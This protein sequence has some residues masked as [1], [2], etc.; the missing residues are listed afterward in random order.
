MSAVAGATPVRDEDAFDVERIANW[1]WEN[2]PSGVG[3]NGIPEVQQF[4]GGASNL[5][6]L[7][8]YGGGPD[9]GGRDLV[10]RRPPTGTKAR[11]AHDMRR[12]H[13]IQAALAPVFPAVPRMV[14]FCADDDVIGSQFYV[15]ERL[16]GTILRRNVPPELGLGPDGIATLCRAAVDTLVALHDVDVESAGLAA[17]DRGDGYVHRQVEGWCGR[18]RRARTD[19]VGDFEATMAWLVSHQPADRPH[20]LI[21]NDF[22]FDNLVLAPGDP[23]RIVGVLDW[24]MA[25]V[26]DPLMDLGAALAYWVQADDSPTFLAVRRQPTHAPGMLTR[27]EVVERYCAARGLE[28]TPEQWRFYDVF[29]AFRLAVIAQQIYFRFHEGQTSNPAYG[30]FREV[31]RFLDHRCAELVGAT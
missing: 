4:V 27:A 22:R 9:A 20:A 19:D 15:M 6:Y 12:E 31:V 30:E 14:A 11:G 13:D 10:L 1:L 21:H 29:G 3:V 2:A 5:T 23:T 26:G 28:V 8:R 16:D 25:T 24:E 7:L 18:Y 17:L